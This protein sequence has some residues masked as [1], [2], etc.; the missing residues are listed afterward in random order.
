MENDYKST[1]EKIVEMLC[2]GIALKEIRE[3]LGIT[4]HHLDDQLQKV[5][6]G[7]YLPYKKSTYK[8]RSADILSNLEKWRENKKRLLEIDQEY[9]ASLIDFDF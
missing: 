3:T 2:D 5:R 6:Y 9:R 7:A 1:G 8:A 4:T